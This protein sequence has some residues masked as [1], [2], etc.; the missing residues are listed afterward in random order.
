MITLPF[1]LL[2]NCKQQATSLQGL[3]LTDGVHC[4]NTVGCLVFLVL[5]ESLKCDGEAM[6]FLLPGCYMTINSL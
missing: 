3:Q 5:I 4:W 6:W 1:Y 2:T